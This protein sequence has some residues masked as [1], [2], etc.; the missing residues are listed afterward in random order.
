[1]EGG[2]GFHPKTKRIS[3]I[4][5]ITHVYVYGLKLFLNWESSV[6]LWK[7]PTLVYLYIFFA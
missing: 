5:F 4:L 7:A 2:A 1:M 6:K 3:P